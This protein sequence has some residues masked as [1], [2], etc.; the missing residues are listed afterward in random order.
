MPE[1]RSSLDTEDLRRSPL[2]LTSDAFVS[3]LLLSLRQIL[4][5]LRESLENT[6]NTAELADFLIIGFL[7]LLGWARPCCF[8]LHLLR[9]KVMPA[10]IIFVVY[11]KEVFSKIHLN[12]KRNGKKQ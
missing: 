4:A 8:P 5:E 6:Q 2:L 10:Q 7:R 1:L 9:R 12:T 3:T 11:R